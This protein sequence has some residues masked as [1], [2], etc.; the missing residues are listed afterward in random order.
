MKVAELRDKIRD[1]PRDRLERLI[2]EMYKAIPKAAKEDQDIDSLILTPN[3]RQ[4]VAKQPTA[5]DMD[6]ISC[7][8][9]ETAEI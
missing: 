6:D 2:V 5:P 4:R 3:P 7:R 9:S 8:A 1:Y